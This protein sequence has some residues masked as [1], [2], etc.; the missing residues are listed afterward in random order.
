MTQLA[1]RKTNPSLPSVSGSGPNQ[2]PPNLQQPPEVEAPWIE[3]GPDGVCVLCFLSGR[4]VLRKE[5]V[6]VRL[7]PGR[8]RWMSQRLVTEADRRG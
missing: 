8:T 7:G 4:R 1:R 3:P 2:R 6:L 5:A